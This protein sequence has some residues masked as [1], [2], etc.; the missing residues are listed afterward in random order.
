MGLLVE[1]KGYQRLSP[2]RSTRRPSK[3][4]RQHAM[5]YLPE[6]GNGFMEPHIAWR[7]KPIASFGF[8]LVIDKTH[9]QWFPS[10]NLGIYVL[11][12][13]NCAIYYSEQ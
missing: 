5:E 1:L 11:S 10:F 12:W 9:V 6:C 2:F 4:D 13:R 8:S 7:K 3:N